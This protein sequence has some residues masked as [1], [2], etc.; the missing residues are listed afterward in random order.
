[1]VHGFLLCNFYFFGWFCFH[2][3]IILTHSR[4][5]LL[6]GDVLLNVNSSSVLDFVDISELL[7]YMK[8]QVVQFIYCLDVHKSGF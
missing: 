8:A 3:T 2:S 5:G 1:M 4:S 6:P 7:S